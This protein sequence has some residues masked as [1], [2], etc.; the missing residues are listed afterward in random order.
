MSFRFS[1]IA[2][3][4]VFSPDNI[5]ELNDS[6]NCPPL[7]FVEEDILEESLDINLGSE[8]IDVLFLTNGTLI[9]TS[10]T[11]VSNM[12]H[13]ENVSAGVKVG[14]F[15]V[16]EVS[17]VMMVTYY[18]NGVLKKDLMEQNRKA[19]L[20]EEIDFNIEYS[21]GFDLTTKLIEFITGESFY[22]HEPDAIV[23]RYEFI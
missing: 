8:F 7:K 20:N 18:E 11:D 12:L 5:K 2:T 19:L 17:M 16:D 21:D 23:F 3:S 14:S 1:A 9:F 15:A 22:I 6:F 10:N 13:I 4:K